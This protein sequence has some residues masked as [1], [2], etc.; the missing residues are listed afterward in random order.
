MRNISAALARRDYD[1]LVEAA[2]SFRK[3]MSPD[4]VAA[5]LGRDYAFSS[6]RNKSPEATDVPAEGAAKKKASRKQ[7]KA[8]RTARKEAAEN[9]DVEMTADSLD[10]QSQATVT[11]SPVAATT[12]AST[13]AAAAGRASKVAAPTSR[14]AAAK[15]AKPSSSQRAAAAPAAAKSPVKMTWAS[16]AKTAITTAAAATPEAAWTVVTGKK[17]TA[18][19]TDS[20]D[21][22]LVLKGAKK[23]PDPRLLRITINGTS[24]MH[25]VAARLSA[26]GNAVLTCASPESRIYLEA[27]QHVRL[28]RLKPMGYYNNKI[29]VTM[30][31]LTP[32]D[33]VKDDSETC[34]AGV[35]P[36][37]QTA[38]AAPD[39]WS[40]TA[41]REHA[42]RPR[43]I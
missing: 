43:Q 21:K 36:C 6:G 13:P 40:R 38:L 27:T 16:V 33:T 31:T 30:A 28:P 17:T 29:F 35:S 19:V 34:P 23:L 1:A 32:N 22:I 20:D 7:R 8:R 41:R 9:M 15:A 2:V 14:P 42:F 26:K 4:L 39:D 5:D 37:P 10:P 11:T 12:T 24:F 25:V 18:T 3:K